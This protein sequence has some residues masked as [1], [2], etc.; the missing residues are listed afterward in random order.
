[1]TPLKVAAFKSKE[2]MGREGFLI[3]AAVVISIWIFQSQHE[4]GKSWARGAQWLVGM[5]FLIYIVLTLAKGLEG[6]I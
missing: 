6:W 3:V 1:M 2:Y 4:K 5:G